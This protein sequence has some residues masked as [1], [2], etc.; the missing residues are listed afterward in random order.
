V[1]LCDMMDNRQQEGHKYFVRVF[2]R[3]E[4]GLSDPLEME[5]PVKVVRPPGKSQSPYFLSIFCLLI[6]IL[7][8]CT[9]CCFGGLPWQSVI[10]HQCLIF[11]KKTSLRALFIFYT[12]CWSMIVASHCQTKQH[13][14]NLV[15]FFIK[16]FKENDLYSYRFVSISVY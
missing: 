15:H 3:N 6:C 8:I 7:C 4:V 16:K 12:W 2:A 9:W 14:A 13:R 11:N 5:E 1:F 10:T